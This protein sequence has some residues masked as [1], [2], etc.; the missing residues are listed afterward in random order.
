MDTIGSSFFMKLVE[1]GQV[2]IPRFVDNVISFL[3]TPVFEFFKLFKLNVNTF[4]YQQPNWLE[5]IF[6]GILDGVGNLGIEFLK[7]IGFDLTLPLWEFIMIHIGLIL[8]I[9]IVLRLLSIVT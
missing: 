6:T 2:Q 4:Q 3:Q 1:I 7:L 9:S 5:S 8:A